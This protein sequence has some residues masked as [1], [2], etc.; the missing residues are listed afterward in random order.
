MFLTA[1]FY[2]F[3]DGLDHLLF[4][5][6]LALPFRRARDLVKP[7]VAFAIAHSIALALAAFGMARLDTWFAPTVGGLMALSLV[8]VSIEN[9]VGRG[10]R[11][12]AGEN[13][14]RPRFLRHRWVVA[15]VFG[16]FHGLG[17]AI[18][19]QESLQFAGS[20]PIAALAAFN[21][22]LELGT[23][24]ILAI[25]V[26]AAN[27]LFSRAAAE[28]A[29]IIVA[30][31][32]VGHVGWHWM[33]ERLAIAQLS[34]WPVMDVNLLLT[35]VRW[36]LAMTVIGGLVWFLSGLIKRKPA[37]QEIP[38]KSIVDSP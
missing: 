14:S 4:V 29:G 1:G 34:S 3:L 13:P 21:V 8:Y 36:L 23:L 2:R 22:G 12:D 20:H 15:F 38:E 33:T 35:V 30:S 32:V 18:A 6:I 5:I 10:F 9:G 25:I 28:R 11:S 24:I 27:L 19:L 7:F 31:V 16:L 37:G 17:F 26:P